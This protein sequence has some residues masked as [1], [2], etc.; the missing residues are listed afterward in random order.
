[1]PGRAGGVVWLVA[2]SSELW[3]RVCDSGEDVRACVCVCVCVCDCCCR[4]CSV[5]RSGPPALFGGR[6]G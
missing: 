5:C 4:V 3:G 1:M 6:V 2:V